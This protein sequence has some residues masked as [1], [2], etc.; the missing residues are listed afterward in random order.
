MRDRC[1]A[2]HRQIAWLLERKLG[3]HGQQPSVSCAR[4]H[5]DHAGVEFALV[6][7]DEGSPEAFDHRRTGWPLEGK[8]R[9]VKCRSC[10]KG[11]F[12]RSPAAALIDRRNRE[13]SWI[14]LERRCVSCHEDPHRNSLGP[15]CERCHDEAAW[16]PASRFD[17]ART[18][19]ALTGAHAKV[20]C[21]KC[22][23]A[24]HLDLP[25]DER[26]NPAP[27][28]KPLPHAECSAC[29]RDPHEG[30]LGRACS[31]CHTTES[32]LKVSREEFDHDRTRYPLRGRHVQL[33]CKACHDPVR[34]WGKRPAFATCGAC[35]RDPHAGKA[36]LGGRAAD[37]G[38]CH[39][40]EGFRPSTYTVAQHRS[41]AYPLEG[42]HERVRCEQC[43]PKNPPGVP[44][45]NLGTAGTLLRPRHERCTDCHEDAHGG[46]LARRKGGI[47]CE[48]CHGVQGWTPSTFTI[49]EHARLRFPLA[50]RHSEIP[51]SSC[52]GPVRRGLRPLPD[53][54]LLGKAG[55]ALVLEELDCVACHAD[56]HGGRFEP[57]GARPKHRRCLHCHDE[58]SFRPS[59]VGVE[60]HGEFGFALEEAHRAV[61]CVDCH[62]EL[63]ARRAGT[64][65]LLDAKSLPSLPFTEKR[66]RCEACH[67][68]PHGDQF[69]RRRD[70]GACDGC[71]GLASFRP[72]PRFD[73]D[74]DS[75]FPLEGAHRNVACHRC[76][77]MRSDPGGRAQ[78]VWR[79]IPSACRD[80]HRQG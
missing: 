43:H 58:R 55:V 51:C 62:R 57:G 61:P 9:E 53:R 30:R 47:G 17:H 36:T 10:H 52:H 7:W 3:L 60:T 79:P 6:S 46:Q 39:R 67:E 29:H 23:R 8:H 44:P 14:G 5:P 65:L 49:A 59:T 41:S 48:P 24:A 70:R 21:E 45:A 75:S 71:H 1:L 31:R 64:S 25:K 2:C 34:A 37:C 40:V 35:H 72:A 16:K 32:F 38:A 26:G 22:H 50:G 69:A 76:H 28:Y 4:C 15:D 19:F 74:R 54:R 33:D 56:P 18:D 77:P 12:Q 78:V 63:A 42:R 11:A 73:H 20:A 27:L 13:E 80:C 66:E 68:N